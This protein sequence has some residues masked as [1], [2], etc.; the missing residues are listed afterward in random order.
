[1]SYIE[2]VQEKIQSSSERPEDLLKL[3]DEIS[4][5]HED[6]GALQVQAEL[7]GRID[8]LSARIEEITAALEQ[9]L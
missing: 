5:A 8:G 1:M 6:G 2:R 7:K 3:W 9:M 4:T